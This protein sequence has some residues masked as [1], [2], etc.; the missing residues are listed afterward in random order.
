MS[1]NHNGELGRALR[2]MEA[3]AATG[4]D[5]IKLQTYTPDTITIDHD[6]PGFRIEGGLWDGRTLYDLYREAHTP[7]EWHETL[8]EKGRELGITRALHAL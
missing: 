1:G 3:A 8:F 4:A 2:L 5:A 6:G 7:F